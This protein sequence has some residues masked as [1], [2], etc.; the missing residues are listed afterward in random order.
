MLDKIKLIAL[1]NSTDSKS[2]QVAIMQQYRDG[3]INPAI[4][5]LEANLGNA[6]S[7][8]I[9]IIIISKSGSEGINLKNTRYV[10]VMEPYWNPVR[11]EQVIGRARR[12]CS[13]KDLPEELRSVEVFLYLMQFTKQQIDS[14]IATSLRQKDRSKFTDAVF[15]SDK[16]LYEISVAKETVSGQIL[17]AIKESA[18]DCEVYNGKS[19]E[20]LQ[21]FTFHNANSNSIAYKPNVEQDP[22][23][24]TAQLNQPVQT[25]RGRLF[26][27]NGKQYIRQPSTPFVY[28]KQMYDASLARNSAA[29]KPVGE[30]RMTRGNETLQL[31]KKL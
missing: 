1:Y 23:D 2:Q 27:F 30:I 15:T 16:M 6:T 19:K 17:K 10:H 14:E 18:I 3:I 22:D 13:H 12:I 31:Y 8:I 4:N 24:I 7:E 25:W 29:L 21:C 11:I 20:N 28:D 5:L 26:T 9:K